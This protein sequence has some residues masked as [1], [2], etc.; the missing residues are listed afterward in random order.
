MKFSKFNLIT[1]LNNGNY[2]LFNT[3][4]GEC[5]IIEE[6]IK[7]IMDN[8]DIRSL[9]NYEIYQ[10]FKEKLII[11]DDRVDENVYIEYFRN[12]VKYDSSYISST[13]LLTWGCN[14][15]CIYCYEG[16][17]SAIKTN[18]MTN[19]TS[20]KYIKFMINN[21][22]NNRVKS[23][24]VNL[25]GGEPLVNIKV[26]LKILSEL[27][28]F[29]DENSIVFSASI[30]TNGTLLTEELFNKLCKL[31]CSSFQVTLDGTKSCHDNRRIYRC[32][33]GSYDEVINC[34]QLLNKNCDKASTVIRV[35]V[36][37]TNL[38]DTFELLKKI[39]KNGI[40]LTNCN[41]DF[42]IVRSSTSACA[43]YSGHCF[44]EDEIGDVLFEL[45]KKA[46][47]EGFRVNTTPHKKWLFCGLYTD[48][49]YTVSP[50]GALFKCWEHTGEEKH[51]IGE[52]GNDGQLERPSY[53]FFD[54]M[55][56]NPLNI[57]T[58][59]DCVYI[60][61]CGGGCGVVSYNR[62]GTY[63]EA[64]CFKVKGV[65]E[66]QVTRYVEKIMSQ[67]GKVDEIYI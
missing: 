61:V 66:K 23:M 14:L 10:D 25:F 31:N 13:V 35:N 57:V 62:S 50:E 30:V 8:N 19:Q 18:S 40:N 60:P 55:S 17:G 47:R 63:H 24:Q 9:E 42:G 41:I 16:A 43:S 5:F 58:C 36:D 7:C 54:W 51:K 11:I 28:Q 38:N 20:E 3:L 64:G 37:K 27:K 6:E 15:A 1:E 65:I 67:D 32:G 12:K 22:L 4:T 2:A 39:G 26:G 29:C 46:E 48:S 34:L 53:A 21:A 49:Q 56:H 52:I 44:I 33:K 45:W 59:K